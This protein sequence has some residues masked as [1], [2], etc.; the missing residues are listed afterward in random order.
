MSTDPSDESED[1]TPVDAEAEQQAVGDT[2]EDL[3]SA[4]LD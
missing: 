2:G 4:I 1:L 3:A